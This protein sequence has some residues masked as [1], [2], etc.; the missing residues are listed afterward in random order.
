MLVLVFY[1]IEKLWQ[2]KHKFKTQLD[3]SQKYTVII[4][5]YITLL[6]SIHDFT[7]LCIYSHLDNNVF[8]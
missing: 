3:A 4:T 8:F 6:G 2:F 5:F 7:L 1:N